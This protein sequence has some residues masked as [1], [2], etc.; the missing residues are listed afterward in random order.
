MEEVK[1]LARDE[2]RL[3]VFQ[4]DKHTCVVPWCKDIAQDAHHI[5][6]RRLWPDGGYYLDNGV[7]LC[8]QHHLHAEY[9]FLSCEDLRNWAGIE[10]VLVPPHLYGDQPYDKW[11]N[12][13]DPDGK[14]RRGELFHDPS[15]QRAL[16]RVMALEPNPFT[17]RVKY[18]RTYHLPW[19]PGV[20]KD[21]RVLKSTSAFE[22]QEVVVTAKM[23]GENTTMYRD[24][25]HSRSLDYSPHESRNWVKTL[26]GK[27]GFEIPEDWRICGE[28]LFAKHAIHY[29]HL[30]SYFMVF[31][32][33]DELNNCLCW[34]DVVTWSSLLDLPTVPVLYRGRWDEEIVRGL[35]TPTLGGDECEGYVV[36]LADSFH[37]KNFK[38][39]VAKYVRA[40]HV[41]TGAAHWRHKAITKNEMV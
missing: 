16:E 20:H 33:W 29:R 37:Y 13:I 14:R 17:N 28:N 21:D 27:I 4:R 11:G 1:L 19:S 35:F 40:E 25:L 31:S 32:V 18:P 36:R 26:H 9:T 30:T 39:V 12:P 41:S 34:D 6:E 2:F 5:I 15:V 38:E 8:E 23:D 7:S 10:N 24:Y 3:Q 22:G